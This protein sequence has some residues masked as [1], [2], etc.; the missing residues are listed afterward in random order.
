MKSSSPASNTADG[1]AGIVVRTFVPDSVK[2]PSKDPSRKNKNIGGVGALKSIPP[3][4]FKDLVELY[5]LPWL[6]P[7]RRTKNLIKK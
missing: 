1:R 4:V 7:M 5:Y 3:R 2:S 6:T